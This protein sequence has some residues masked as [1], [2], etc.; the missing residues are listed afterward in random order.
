MVNVFI[1]DW[2]LGKCARA[3]YNKHVVKLIVEATQLLSNAHHRN[4][5]RLVIFHNKKR[6]LYKPFC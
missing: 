3:H 6:V 1:L 4:N 5:P 2:D